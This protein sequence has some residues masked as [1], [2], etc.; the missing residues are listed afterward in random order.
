M[1]PFARERQMVRVE[2]AGR[3]GLAAEE[4]ADGVA[5]AADVIAV[6]ADEHV[7]RSDLEVPSGMSPVSARWFSGIS[8]ACGESRAPTATT[9][10]RRSAMVSM[11]PSDRTRITLRRSRSVSRM[12]MASARRPRRAAMR[13][14]WSHASGEFHA[15]WTCPRR[16]A[17][18]WRS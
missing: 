5:L 11:P 7:E 6:L 9:L 3:V 14:V 16:W 17:S 12:Q 18:T 8:V 13:S 4:R 15:T 1:R 10:P 2:D